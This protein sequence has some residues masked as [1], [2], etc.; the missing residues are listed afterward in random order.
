MDVEN[1]FTEGR[2][3]DDW[4]KWIYEESRNSAEE[5]GVSMPEFVDFLNMGWYEV[6]PPENHT[7]MLEAFCRN[8][9]AEPLDTPSGKNRN[10][11]GEDLWFRICRLPGS[12]G[13]A[14]T[15]RVVG[16]G[17]RA[18]PASPYFQSAGN[19]TAF[20]ARSWKHEPYRKDSKG[21]SRS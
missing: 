12:P 11:F 18:V 17:G 20:P 16:T 21:A 6:E 9:T 1:D 2:S 3:S 19:Q 15:G 14:G 5:S 7:I 8:P 10:F 13:L 4:I